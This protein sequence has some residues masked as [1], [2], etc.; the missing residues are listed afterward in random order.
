MLLSITDYWLPLSLVALC[1][2]MLALWS[3]RN[4]RRKLRR[5]REAE[6]RGRYGG[7]PNP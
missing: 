5:E 7:G 2:G 3:Y 1:Y 4:H 6:E